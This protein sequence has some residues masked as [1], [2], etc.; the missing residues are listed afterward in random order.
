MSYYNYWKEIILLGI[1]DQE[2]EI[3]LILKTQIKKIQN[4]MKERIIEIREEE[5]IKTDPIKIVKVI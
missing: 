4:L 1:I 5:E 3:D 2:R